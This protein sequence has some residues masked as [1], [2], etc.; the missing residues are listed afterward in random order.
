MDENGVPVE[1]KFR[2][3]SLTKPSVYHESSA[4]A[5]QNHAALTEHALLKLEAGPSD[6]LLSSFGPYPEFEQICAST[7][8]TI[9]TVLMKIY[10]SY[11]SSVPKE[12]LRSICRLCMKIIPP[13]QTVSRPNCE[14]PKTLPLADLIAR[15]GAR[16]HLSPDFL[17]ELSYSIYFCLYNDVVLEGRRALERIHSTALYNLYPQCLLMTNAMRNSLRINLSYQESQESPLDF[18]LSTLSPTS[19]TSIPTVTAGI[20]KTAI[21]NAS[22]K[23]RKLP[24]DIPI[25]TA[26]TGTNLASIE[27]A[28]ETPEVKIQKGGGKSQSQHTKAILN[29]LTQKKDKKKEGKNKHKNENGEALKVKEDTQELEVGSISSG[30]SDSKSLVSDP[31][32][33]PLNQINRSLLNSSKVTEND[34]EEERTSDLSDG[35]AVTRPLVP[36]EGNHSEDGPREVVA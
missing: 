5:I 17:V 10:N 25:I 30:I 6:N 23:T 3:P 28:E 9:F 20:S 14:I 34:V 33:I 29:L 4:F 19:V 8:M 18:N 32:M 7:R 35:E 26:N 22:F 21:T 27:E 2:V 15:A 31:E 1:R 24:E 16:V 36:N 12:S 11:L 13:T